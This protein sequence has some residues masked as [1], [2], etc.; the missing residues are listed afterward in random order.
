[1]AWLLRARPAIRKAK[2]PSKSGAG[3]AK[4]RLRE[5]I[6]CVPD[7]GYVFHVYKELL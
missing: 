3:G 5:N 6:K 2:I 4:Y 1:M 7:K